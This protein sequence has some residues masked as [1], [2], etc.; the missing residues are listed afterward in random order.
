MVL[1]PLTGN[2]SCE[3]RRKAG[4]FGIGSEHLKQFRN[5]NVRDIANLLTEIQKEIMWERQLDREL[6]RS[7]DRELERQSD[8]NESCECCLN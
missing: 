2:E 8:E 6:E 4:K 5:I 3:N 1:F 7:L